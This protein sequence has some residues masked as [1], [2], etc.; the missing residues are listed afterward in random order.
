MK[1]LIHNYQPPI[2]FTIQL[3]PSPPITLSWILPQQSL[4]LSCEDTLRVTHMHHKH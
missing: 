3:I 1:L 4:T 2:K